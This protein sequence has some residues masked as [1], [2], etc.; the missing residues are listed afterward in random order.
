MTEHHQHR[1]DW[2]FQGPQEVQRLIRD[3]EVALP[4]VSQTLG[5]FDDH[6]IRRVLDVGAGPGIGTCELARLLPKAQVIALEPSQSMVEAGRSRAADLGVGDRVEVRQGGLPDGLAGIVDIDL[7]WASMSL[8]HV[9]DEVG[10]LRALGAVLAPS[11]VIALVERAGAVVEFASLD[12]DLMERLADAYEGYFE[13]MREAIDHHVESSDL[14]EM[15][16][17]AGLR[18]V[19]DQESSITH[20]PTL[21]ESQRGYLT[22]AVA[23][24]IH[25]LGDSLTSA[26]RDSLHTFAADP[27]GSFTLTRRVLI[28]SK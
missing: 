19:S 21:D 16:T 22:G 7:V 6:S 3:G 10:A 9:A 14:A 23:R 13:Q 5:Q 24:V 17:A 11:G 15:V 28:A 27:T 4:F 18:V 2:A 8:H 20:G 25:Q 26:D 1:H 12:S